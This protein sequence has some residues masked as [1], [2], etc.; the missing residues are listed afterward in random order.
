MTNWQSVHRRLKAQLQRL[1]G[2]IKA[3]EAAAE[4]GRQR[5]ARLKHQ[6][7]DLEQQIKKL[8]EENS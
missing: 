6:K 1:T 7:A 2:D 5:L 8:L 4:A 3:A